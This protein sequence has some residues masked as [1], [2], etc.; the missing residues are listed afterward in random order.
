MAC[1]SE[2]IMQQCNE[3]IMIVIIIHIERKQSLGSSEG[4]TLSKLAV[5]VRIRGEAN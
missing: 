3:T 4:E 5:P 2:T 1:C